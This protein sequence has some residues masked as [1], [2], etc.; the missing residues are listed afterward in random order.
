MPTF[1]EMMGMMAEMS[2]EQ[3][4]AAMMENKKICAEYCGVCPSYTG[5]GE[6]ELMFCATG[7]SDKITEER[8]CIC[9]G[10]PVQTQKM[11]LRWDFY[12][13]KGSGREQS[14]AEKGQ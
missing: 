9:G 5:T 13:T 8:G 12:C 10:C 6:T 3:I 7:K 11:N 14:A 1:E 4:N 2:E